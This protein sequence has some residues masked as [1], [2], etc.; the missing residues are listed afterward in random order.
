MQAVF[1]AFAAWLLLGLASSFRLHFGSLKSLHNASQLEVPFPATQATMSSVTEVLGQSEVDFTGFMTDN[2]AYQARKS[3]LW[4]WVKKSLFDGRRKFT[5][6]KDELVAGHVCNSPGLPRSQTYYA[7]SM[8][9][10]LPEIKSSLADHDHG[11]QGPGLKWVQNPPGQQLCTAFSGSGRCVKCSVCHNNGK[12]ADGLVEATAFEEDVLSLPPCLKETEIELRCKGHFL[13]NHTALV[14]EKRDCEEVQGRYNDAVKALDANLESQRANERLIDVTI[15]ADIR[16]TEHQISRLQGQQ[17]ANLDTIRRERRDA[18]SACYPFRGEYWWSMLDSHYHDVYDVLRAWP[19][20]YCRRPSRPW[21]DRWDHFDWECQRQWDN[22]DR[23]NGEY[24]E[25]VRCRDAKE[26]V[27][28][29]ADTLRRTEQDISS[30]QSQLNRLRDDLVR[31]QQELRRLQGREPG[32]RDAKAAMEAEWLPQSEHCGGVY[33]EYNNLLNEWMREKIPTFYDESCEKACLQSSLKDAGCGVMEGVMRG[34]I[35]QEGAAGPNP[36][37]DVVCSPPSASFVLTPTKYGAT[38]ET[39]FDMCKRI[40]ENDGQMPR[41]PQSIVEKDLLWKRERLWWRWRTR[42]FVL[43]SGDA[44]RSAV[45]RYWTKN[46]SEQG[47]EERGDK[48]IILWDAVSVVSKPG[49]KYRWKNGEE[50]FILKH[51]YREYILCSHT[52]GAAVRDRWVSLIGPEITFPT[53]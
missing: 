11:S 18:E 52:G 17:S 5:D 37:I 22:Y 29:G 28:D 16:S 27:Q 39:E 4:G 45:I 31:A 13:D 48:T 12:N 24:D 51:F 36:G 50:C 33:E 40:Y 10:W 34:E 7:S 14:N 42:Y 26:Q 44:V 9:Y 43:E 3:S 15:P 23:E 47:A 2:F 21:C 25:C 20:F 41:R 1:S 53:K 30:Q 32:L 6:L 8:C 19:D 35:W 46:P 38:P 49:S